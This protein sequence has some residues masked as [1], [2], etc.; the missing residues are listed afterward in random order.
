M[1]KIRLSALCCLFVICISATSVSAQFKATKLQLQDSASFSLVLLP[2][3]QNYVKFDYNQPVL[4]LMTAWIADNVE[5]LNIKAVMCTG[6]IVDQNELIVNTSAKQGNVTSRQQWEYASHAFER[7]DNRVPYIL[8]PGNHDYGYTGAQNS[9][10]HY[11]EYFTVERNLKNKGVLV[12]AT[13]NRNGY[14][15]L[16]N[17]AWEIKDPNWGAFL[18]INVEFGVRD[19]VLAWAKKLCDSKRYANHKVI[20][21]LHAYMGY[22]NP[23]KLIETDKY[24]ITPN[25]R[26]KDVWEKFVKVT[27]NV[28]MV[29]CGHVAKHDEKMESANGWLVSKN[30]AGKEV[31]QMMFDTQTIGG[32][33]SGNGGDGWLRLLEFLPDG[34]TVKAST[35]SPLFGFSTRTNDIAVDKT[36]C[37]NFSFTIE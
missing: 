35:Y 32:G 1:K 18:I 27:P 28:R 13:Y 2:D 10:T 24:K 16:E 8:A 4:E 33:W 3:I 31:Y 37:N 36:P 19:E 25:N 23:A 34:K 9:M 15:T 22:G 7:L 30:D 26:G 14:P 5:P 12:A 21:L 6:D 29:L 17:A 20:L 11:P